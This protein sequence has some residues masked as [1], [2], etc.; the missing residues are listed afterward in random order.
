MRQSN[1]IRGSPDEAEHA[2]A[3]NDASPRI[4]LKEMQNGGVVEGNC[5]KRQ[6]ANADNKCS[7]FGTWRGHPGLVVEFFSARSVLIFFFFFFFGI[8]RQ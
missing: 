4:R 1:G 8:L 7:T 3:N 2:K 6:N 5:P